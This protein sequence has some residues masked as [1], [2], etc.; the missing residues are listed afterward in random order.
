MRVA[1]FARVPDVVVQL[2]ALLRELGHECVGVVTTEGPRGR[3]GE[4]PLSDLLDVR[5][6]HL[7][8]L[9][10]S[11]SARFAK[12]LEAL[13]PDLALC[14]GFPVR[15]PEDALAVP[16][17]GVVNGHPALLPR[18]RIRPLNDPTQS[19][20]PGKIRIA[21]MPQGTGTGAGHYT[22][23]WVRYFGVTPHARASKER[24][25]KALKLVEW[26]GGKANN[27][28]VFQKMLML[29]LGVPFCT[30]PLNNDKD[31]IAFYDKWVGGADIINKQASLAVTK[32]VIAPW[33]GEWN[34]TNNQAW[35]SIFLGKVT[36]E[37]GLK[38]SADKWNELK[39]QG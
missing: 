31:I 39:K 23:G 34:E 4:D 25:A 29:D 21:L 5:P 24:E 36:A 2:D 6:P 10:A 19:Q 20:V 35:Q 14:G 15:I 17:H 11:G 12:L 9:V 28:Y 22:C 38:A 1:L 26:F 27:E 32:D 16:R 13:E 33:F 30:T 3:Y 18:Y 37:A 8:V 7:D